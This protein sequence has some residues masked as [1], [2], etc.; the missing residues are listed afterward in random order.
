ME[1]LL[2][3]ETITGQ[4]MMAI[5]EGKDPALADNYGA[6]PESVG[7]A[8]GPQEPPKAVSAAETNGEVSSDEKSGKQNEELPH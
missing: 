1:Y 4:E 2:K 8:Q 7:S 3:K 6:D 5:L